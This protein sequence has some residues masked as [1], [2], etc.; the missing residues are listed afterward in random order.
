MDIIGFSKTVVLNKYLN[1]RFYAAEIAVGLFFLHSKGIIYRDLKLD[2]VM[3]EKDGHIKI[4]DFGMCKE[5]IFGDATT[6][7]FCGTP[8]SN[9]QSCNRAETTVGSR[10]DCLLFYVLIV[11][12]VAGLHCT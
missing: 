12:F 11:I 4:T 6:K 2:N 9:P 3:L 1:F 7:T 10:Q 5:G 8:V